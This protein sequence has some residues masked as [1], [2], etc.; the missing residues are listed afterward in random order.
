MPS[1]RH[2]EHR[3]FHRAWSPLRAVL[4]RRSLYRRLALPRLC[5][6]ATAAHRRLSPRR[7]AAQPRT[8]FPR[9]ALSKRLH[10]R[11]DPDE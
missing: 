3:S 4:R 8:V 10:G 6:G 11:S 5:S 1:E 9:R 7:T 2:R